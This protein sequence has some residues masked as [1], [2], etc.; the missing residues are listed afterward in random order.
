MKSELVHA[1]A[2]LQDLPAFLHRRLGGVLADVILRERTELFCRWPP[3]QLEPVGIVVTIDPPGV[4]QLRLQQAESEQPLDGGDAIN[5][6][7]DE[8]IHGDADGLEPSPT[9]ELLDRHAGFVGPILQEGAL[10]SSP[11]PTG[12]NLS[13]LLSG[14]SR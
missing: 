14:S 6:G 13:V 4:D 7:A 1:F 9:F 10:N 5:V 12:S 8:V 11:P 3:D 2:L